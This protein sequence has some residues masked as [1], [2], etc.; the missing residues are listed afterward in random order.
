MGRT[1][2]ESVEDAALENSREDIDGRHP[3]RKVLFEEGR[4]AWTRSPLG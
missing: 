1:R 4:G 3:I 2:S